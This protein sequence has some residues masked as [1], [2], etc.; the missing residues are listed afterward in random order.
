MDP[1]SPRPVVH[2]KRRKSLAT[3]L[4]IFG[5][6]LLVICTGVVGAAYYLSAKELHRLKNS[7]AVSADQEAR[8]LIGKIGEHMTLPS[9]KPTVATV[10]DTK[11]LT[12]QAF[13]KQARNGD[14]VLMY[15]QSKK[16]ILY[17]PSTDKII[18]VAYLHIENKSEADDKASSAN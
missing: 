8:E 10:E 9:E 2:H 15:T 6:L 4:K 5:V 17:R 16:A 1:E 11:K 12:G 7:P 14:K 18:E 3:K 13:F